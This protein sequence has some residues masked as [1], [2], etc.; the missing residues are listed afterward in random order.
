MK[1]KFTVFVFL[2]VLPVF[3]FTVG[4][5]YSDIQ[6]ITTLEEIEASE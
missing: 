4:M 3:S 6:W 2:I 1:R 5:V